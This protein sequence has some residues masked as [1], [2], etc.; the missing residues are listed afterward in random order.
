M[1][2]AGQDKFQFICSELEN[3]VLVLGDVGE[4]TGQEEYFLLLF[5]VR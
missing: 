3:G 5:L 4:D 2:E 1:C